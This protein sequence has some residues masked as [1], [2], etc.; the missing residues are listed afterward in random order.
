[1]YFP[2]KHSCLYIA[3]FLLLVQV[4]I[5]LEWVFVKVMLAQRFSATCRREKFVHRREIEVF[6]P[7]A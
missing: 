5:F 4:N 6:D 7:Q 1:M 2:I 3:T